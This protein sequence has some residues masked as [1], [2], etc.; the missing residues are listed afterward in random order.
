M[1]LSGIIFKMTFLFSDKLLRKYLFAFNV[2]VYYWQPF[3][4][5]MFFCRGNDRK[6]ILYISRLHIFKN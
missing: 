5:K 6:F 3:G 2:C 1:E 4:L